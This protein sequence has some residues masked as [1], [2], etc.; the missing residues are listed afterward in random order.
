MFNKEL[1]FTLTF[2]MN[3]FGFAVCK[4]AVVYLILQS[5]HFRTFQNLILEFTLVFCSLFLA[6]CVYL[7]FCCRVLVLLLVNLLMCFSSRCLVTAFKTC[8][9][10]LRLCFVL[11]F[12]VC[13]SAVAATY[14]S[15]VCEFPVAFWTSQPCVWCCWGFFSSSCVFWFA[16]T[17]LGVYF[18]TLGPL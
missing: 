7:S 10:N 15:C 18:C 6:V 16:V 17:S 4:F 11:W 5:E 9:W 12:C 1:P 13:V 14:L 2:E 8:L 3:V